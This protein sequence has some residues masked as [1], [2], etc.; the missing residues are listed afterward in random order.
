MKKI[1]FIVI[2]FVFGQVFSQQHSSYTVKEKD[3][4]EWI[5]KVFRLSPNDIKAQNPNVKELKKGVIL[6][7]P[8][9]SAVYF[10]TKTPSHFSEH[11]VKDKE[12]LFGIAGQYNVSQDD[13]RRYNLSLYSKP[14]QKEQKLTIP[15]FSGE[16]DD[17][18]KGKEGLNPYIVKPKEGKW[19]I[20]QNHGISVEELEKINPNLP[21]V[22]QEGMVIFVPSKYPSNLHSGVNV[23]RTLVMYQVEKGEGFFSLERKFNITEAELIKINPEL[24]DGIKLEAQIW[25]PK[26]NFMQYVSSLS[27]GVTDFAYDSND[28]IK[29]NSK[30]SRTQKIS[31]VLPFNVESIS[32]TSIVALK[33]KLQGDKITSVATDFYSGVLMAVDSLAKRG[34]NFEMEV[35]DSQSSLQ[36]ISSAVESGRLKNSQVVIGPFVAAEFNKLSQELQDSNVALIAPLSNR[37]IE[38]RPNVFQSVPTTE[39]QQQKM[40]NFISRKYPDVN[41][42]FLSDAK[43]KASNEKLSTAFFNGKEVDNIN[44]I[45][46]ALDKTKTNIVFA[47]SNDVVFLSD[48]IRILYNLTGLASKNQEYNIIMATLDKGSAYDHTSISNAQLSALKFTYPSVNRYAGEMNN[49][50]KQYYEIYKVSP[51]RYAFRGFD[52]MMDAVLRTSIMG[53]F[54]GVSSSIGET[55]YQENKFFY[56][57]KSH[58]GGGFENEGVYIVRYDDLEVKEI[59]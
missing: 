2:L 9:P 14:L 43:N 48:V 7:I 33:N 56:V 55:S 50:I 8:S 28:Y 53:D 44:N 37:N 59:H 46:N 42:V 4:W 19:R 13:L 52:I 57:K 38:L 26:E 23:E 54:V 17:V 25:I 29:S 21:E 40:I 16:N 58:K 49:F 6:I 10:N 34:F 1:F 22:L 3:T 30:A 39:I 12:T 41:V 20:A 45:K 18:K 51:S 47:S 15:V 5:A 11:L 36:G 24:K 31:L 35:L 27:G 32:S